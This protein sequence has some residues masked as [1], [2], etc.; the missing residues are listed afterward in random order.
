MP[1]AG[2][3]GYNAMPILDA[4]QLTGQTRTHVLEFKEFGFTL[5][6]D[7]A[8]AFLALRRAAARDGLDV[9]AAS[10]FRD[11]NRQL[12]I[13]NDKYLGRR[14]LLDRDGQALDPTQMSGTELVQAI[15][16]WSALPGASR[17]HWGTEIDVFDRHA[18]GAQ[19]TPQLVPA[20][21]APTGLFAPLDRWLA[22]HAA[23]YGFFRPYDL[24]RGG[25]RPEPWHLSFAPLAEPAL[26][27]L[28]LAVLA[29]ALAGVELAGA[30]DIA[31]Q[32]SD[33]HARYVSAVASPGTLALSAP[34]LSIEASPATRPS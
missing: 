29:A 8:H 23:D 15:L 32:L 22:T 26:K 24:D 14:A 16:Q 5:Q 2:P 13:W 21:F 1:Y 27:G 12:T 30:A 11:F 18:L 6:P 31:G 17:H 19:H 3:D 33:I 10:S 9:T 28:S 7:A 34:A 25:V 20:E 4:K